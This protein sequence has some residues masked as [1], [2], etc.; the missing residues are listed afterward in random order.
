MSRATDPKCIALLA[1]VRRKAAIPSQDM[2][3]SSVQASPSPTI[4]E[5]SAST[6][7]DRPEDTNDT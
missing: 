7:R 4:V 5:A 2:V 6:K 1:S 3:V